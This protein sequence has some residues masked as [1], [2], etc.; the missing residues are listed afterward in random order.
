MMLAERI[1]NP[2]AEENRNSSGR[3][4]P[5]SG[6]R[7]TLTDSRGTTKRSSR[8]TDNMA[9]LSARRQK[10][11]ARAAEL[12]PQ[13][14]PLWDLRQAHHLTGARVGKTLKI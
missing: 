6:P 9:E 11:E 5:T 2:L 10:I 1:A 4:Q 7:T 3:K 8:C 12:A 13:E 14:M